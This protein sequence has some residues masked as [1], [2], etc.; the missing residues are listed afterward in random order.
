MQVTFHRV[1]FSIEIKMDMA[2][3]SGQNK[4]ECTQKLQPYI[5]KLENWGIERKSTLNAKKIE[6]LT[7][8]PLDTA[9]GSL[10]M[11]NLVVQEVVSDIWGLSW[12]RVVDGESKLI[13]WW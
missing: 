3:G 1:Y 12:K 6:A 5:H 4:K 10:Y 7:I 2:R 9:T 11:D 8:A 13:L